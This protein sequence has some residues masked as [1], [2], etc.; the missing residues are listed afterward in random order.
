MP[1]EDWDVHVFDVAPRKNIASNP[2]TG[3]AIDPEGLTLSLFTMRLTHRAS[4]KTLDRADLIS[5]PTPE[6]LTAY[7]RG[8]IEVVEKNMANQKTETTPSPLVGPLVVV[9][10]APPP[11]APDDL[12]AFQQ[13]SDLLAQLQGLVTSGDLSQTAP[14]VV[15][16][17]NLVAK[18]K[19]RAAAQKVEQ[20]AAQLKAIQD[21]TV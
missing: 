19:A 6:A 8:V 11:F 16:A 13:A 7:A 18:F 21:G 9:P 12:S 1:F 14:V 15:K 5:T 2:L 20:I 17:T 10:P 4:G 3:L